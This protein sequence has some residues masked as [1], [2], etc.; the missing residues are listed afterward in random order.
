MSWD[1]QKSSKLYGIDNWSSGYFKIN[2]KGNVEILPH[3]KNGSSIDLFELTKDLNDRGINPPIL[4]R[5]PDIVKARVELLS[6]C[7][8]KAMKDYNYT[9]KYQGVF[10]IK[11][12]QQNHLIQEIVNFGK[13][14]RLGLECGSKPELLI[15]LALMNTEDALIICNGFK[16][17]EYIETALLSQ[18]LGR[19]TYIVVDRFEELNLIIQGS[20]KLNIRPKIG[21]RAKLNAQGAGKWVESSGAKSKFGLTPSEIVLG[22]EVLKS[23]DLLDSLELLHFHIGSQITSIQAIKSSLKEAVR[24]FTEFYTLGASLKYLD[25]GGGLGVDYD[26]SG[27]GTDNST[28]YNEQ[29]YANDVIS[30][31]QSGCEEKGIPA[32]DIITEAGRSLVAY[33]SILIF[34]VLGENRISKPHLDIKVSDKDTRLVRELHDIY[35]ELD[36]K[37]LNEFYNDLLEKKRDT[38]NMFSYGV[39]SLEQRAKAEDLYWAITTKMVQIAKESEDAEGIFWD[40]EKELS[41]TYYGNFSIFQS[42]PDCWALDQ[43]FPVMPIHR[44][45]EAPNRRAILVD[46]TCDSDGKLDKFIDVEAGG[47]QGYLEVHELNYNEPY[48]LGVFLTGAYQET[49]GDLHNLFGDTNAVHVSTCEDGKGY[50]IAGVVRGDSVE[51]VLSYV[52]YNKPELVE[53]IRESSEKSIAEGKITT[54]EAKLLMN[55]YTQALSG[56]T[57]LEDPDD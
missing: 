2:N 51:E 52:E 55:Y 38:M 1:Y 35:K 29:E 14:R 31:I 3:G 28:N 24:F 19:N 13:S 25:V 46:M 4:I 42:L 23:E 47:T 44:L 6:N 26:G 57:Y 36:P 20:K 40:L 16:D 11:V 43:I 10:P 5:L 49:L 7:F 17:V 39:L 54:Q 56:Y 33:S 15:T 21:F 50:K 41:D 30:I 18:K 12:N 37:N 27:G 32:P 34:N 22:I 8:E 53:K 48:Y 9:G 45:N